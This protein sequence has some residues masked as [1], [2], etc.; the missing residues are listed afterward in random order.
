M[1]DKLLAKRC[2]LPLCLW[3]RALPLFVGELLSGCLAVRIFRCRLPQ[4]LFCPEI[5]CIRPSS[6]VQRP[7][8]N[9][10]RLWRIFALKQRTRQL[11]PKALK[12]ENFTVNIVLKFSYP[13][14]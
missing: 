9:A 2:L 5:R 14:N 8:R 4:L 13:A 12:N 10:H 7:T 3:Q 11:T 1:D 6:L